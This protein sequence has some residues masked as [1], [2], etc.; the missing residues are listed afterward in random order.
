MNRPTGLLIKGLKMFSKTF[1]FWHVNFLSAL[2]NFDGFNG[3][4]ENGF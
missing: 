4:H 3:S 1:F 2:K